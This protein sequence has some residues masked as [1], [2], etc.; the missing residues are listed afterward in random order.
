MTDEDIEEMQEEMELDAEMA[1]QQ[2]L[3]NPQQDTGSG[4][5]DISANEQFDRSA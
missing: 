5:E 4:I 2:A 1:A 3:E